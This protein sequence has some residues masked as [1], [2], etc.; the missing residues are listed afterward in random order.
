[1]ATVLHKKKRESLLTLALALFAAAGCCLTAAGGSWLTYAWFTVKRVQTVDASDMV[2]DS[3][4]VVSNVKLYPYHV[5]T[6]NEGTA[7]D[8]VLTFEHDPVTNSA[9]QHMGY[10]S[11]LKQKQNGILL[12]V[13]IT[14]K[15]QLE[16]SYILAAHSNAD[17][18]LGELD[19]TTGKLKKALAA[20]DNSLSSI[21]RFYA[22]S[23]ITDNSTYYS[24]KL[25][26][27]VNN[28][29]S[30]LTFV[31]SDYKLN[32]NVDIATIPGHA[33]KVYFVIDYSPELIE[34]IYSANIGNSAI[35]DITT[36]NAEGQSFI[37][38][39]WDFYFYINVP[40]AA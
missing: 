5:L 24:V 38:F 21:I 33:A 35:S 12:E 30:E 15:A 26:D 39:L 14:E 31:S 4:D 8:T 23:T 22:F 34:Y 28:S 1:M 40:N 29:G 11:I 36:I 6:S 13:D 16:S 19:A 20:A 37:S 18:F 7:Q 3:Y 32:Q 10:Y 2:S 27:T 17:C 25:S 9:D